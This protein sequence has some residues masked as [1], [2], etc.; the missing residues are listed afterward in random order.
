MLVPS[1]GVERYGDG[2]SESEAFLLEKAASVIG[3][4]ETRQ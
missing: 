4:V 3:S 1:G 2:E